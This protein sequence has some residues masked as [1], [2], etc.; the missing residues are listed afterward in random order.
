MGGLGFGSY[1]GGILS[2]KIGKAKSLKAFILIELAI[3][4]IGVLSCFL[5][6]DCLYM[7]ASWLYSSLLMMTISHFISLLIPTFLMGMSLPFLVHA[8]VQNHKDASKTIGILYGLNII[9]AC[10]GAFITPWI[11]IPAIGI[12]G[13]AYTGAMCNLIAGLIALIAG[14]IS[15][16]HSETDN[17]NIGGITISKEIPQVS[18]T[19]FSFKFW[20]FL[21]SL[22]G[23]IALALEII[24]FRIL[25]VAVKSNAFTFGTI[26][27][28]YLLGLAIGTF[29]GSKITKGN[30]NPL[31]SFLSYQ[32]II[33]LYTCFSIMAM[34]YLPVDSPLIEILNSSNTMRGIS[35]LYLHIGLSFYFCLVPTI[36]MGL[37]FTVLQ[38]AV[39][40][41]ENGI[42]KKVGTLQAF[43]ILGNVLGSLCV[44]LFLI[45]YYGTSGSLIFLI[46]IGLFFPIIGI[47]HF[48]KQRFFQVTTLMLLGLIFLLP[49]KNKLWSRLHGVEDNSAMF[50]ENASGLIG[51]LSKNKKYFQ[52]CINGKHHSA[53]P[54]NGNYGALAAV[55]HPNP[56]NAA[57]IGLATGD[58]A[59]GVGCRSGIKNIKVYEVVLALDL[60]NECSKY[61]EDVEN[62]LAD[63]RYSII[64][65]DGRNALAKSKE[66][67]DIIEADALRP[68][69]AYAGNLYSKEYFQLCYDRLNE[70]GIIVQLSMTPRTTSTF[71]EVFPYVY[72]TGM[73][74]IGSKKP[75]VLDSSKMNW[76]IHSKK[77]TDYLGA[78]NAQSV[79]EY[80]KAIKVVKKEDLISELEPN[81]D[82][83]P[84]D[85]FTLHNLFFQ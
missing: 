8:T 22:S 33:L 31:V 16:N 54:Y 57:I 81:Q 46:G 74:L 56:K 68:S 18:S 30:K 14:T 40:N 15:L 58:T 32:T 27:S 49:S 39:H 10:T 19:T 65:T 21:Y 25:D 3:S 34:V 2:S 28:V 5:Y 71:S 82:L 41:N 12:P 51:V 83:Y 75:I 50:S 79:W 84:R 43:N 45:E 63:S 29:L 59:W 23:F 73:L 66:K 48:K 78:Y 77:I 24:W 80:Y 36:F 1:Y 13:A 37:S 47:Y 44:G 85:E 42:G 9:G 64:R 69:S 70:E 6:Y 67:F 26:L 52:Y 53:I 20:V 7:N 55:L 35:R 11:L 62:F 17:N 76:L 38:E 61:N 4:V 72:K 60:L